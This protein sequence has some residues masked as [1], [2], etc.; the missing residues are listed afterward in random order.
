M[1]CILLAGGLGTRLQGVI[2]DVPKC[3]A[4]INGQ[5]FLHYVFDYLEQQRC[6]HAILSLGHKHRV[7]LDWLK[8]QQRPFQVDYVIETEPLGTGGGISL[9]MSKAITENIAVLNG[10]TM[11]GIDLN[12]LLN[13]HTIK[14]AT[15]T[16][17]LKPMHNFNRYGVVHTNADACITRFEEKKQY[18][19]G[20]IN[21]GVYM[22]NRKTLLSKNLPAKY[23]FEKDYLEA[24][25]Y[26]HMFFGFS[27]DA[28]FIDIG[29]PEDYNKAQTDFKTLLK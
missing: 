2:G 16:L 10:D 9:A 18:D 8:T 17:A 6:T 25:V 23:S 11:F 14:K 12:E 20:L 22:I 29:I 1:E 3:M 5:P 15:T 28:Y 27:S 4:P 21:G 19:E 24:F 13:F 7:V 26:E